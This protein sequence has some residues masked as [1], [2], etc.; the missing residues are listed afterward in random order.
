MQNP[1]TTNRM[2]QIYLIFY[3]YMLHE[4]NYFVHFFLVNN[5]H[6]YGTKKIDYMKLTIV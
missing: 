3:S 1:V 2:L 6:I 5:L 4:K